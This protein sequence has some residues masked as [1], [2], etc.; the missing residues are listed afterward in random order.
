MFYYTLKFS[1]VGQKIPNSKISLKVPNFKWLRSLL[2]IKI[3]Q[4]NLKKHIAWQLNSKWISRLN[5]L[6][7]DLCLSKWKINNIKKLKEKQL[8]A[9]DRV[10]TNENYWL[11]DDTLACSV[12]IIILWHLKTS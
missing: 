2:A 10:I 8:T 4:N 1:S 6:T 12:S 7:F 3:Q 9:C 5:K 11:C